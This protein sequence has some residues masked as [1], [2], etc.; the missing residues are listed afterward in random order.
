MRQDLLYAL[1]GLVRMPGLSAIIIASLALAIGAN[2]TVFTWLEGMVLRPY[3]VVRDPGRLA[4][5]NTRAPNGDE[6]SV[7]YQTLKDWERGA[8]T[9]AGIGAFD[10]AQVN[11]KDGQETS[12]AWLS[13]VTGNY[14]DLLGVPALRGRTLTPEDEASASQVA[15]LG[16][17]YWRRR[18]GGDPG[19]I[20]RQ[21]ALNGNGFTV[22]GVLPPRFGGLNVGLVFDVFVPVTVQPVLTPGNILVDRGHMTLEAFTRF[23]PGVTFAQARSELESVAAEVARLH[24][25]EQEGV[26]IRHLYERGA[27]QIMLP[28][29]GALLGVTVLVLVIA[30]A[31][32][33]NMLLPGPG[34][35][36]RRSRC[37]WPS[38]RP[39]P[40]WCAS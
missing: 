37:A 15:V 12:R 22:V 24:D 34:R 36:A 10:L 2:T 4:W 1:R 13:M 30:C 39:G 8:R 14:F 35:G 32:I 18:F 3:P 5:V 17:D 20:G 40:G 6:W 16:H 38:A 29:L 26:L 28:V 11:L 33:A 25:R 31:N 27:A 19:V 7:S 23:G 21:V 9:V